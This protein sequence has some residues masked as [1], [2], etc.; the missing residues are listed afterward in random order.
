MMGTILPVMQHYKILNYTNVK[1]SEFVICLH[2]C[3]S[4]DV[5]SH[6]LWGCVAL[7]KVWDDY[8]QQT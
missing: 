1:I 2:L 4:L 8:K 3:A 7:G 5:Y 6:I